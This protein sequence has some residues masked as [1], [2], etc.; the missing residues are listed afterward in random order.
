M[1]YPKS[2]GIILCGM[3]SRLNEQE[4]LFA[5]VQKSTCA[6]VMP[7]VMLGLAEWE[8]ELNVSNE[9]HCI[10]HFAEAKSHTHAHTHAHKCSL[11]FDIRYLMCGL[12]NLVR[13]VIWICKNRI[14]TQIPI[15]LFKHHIDFCTLANNASCASKREHIPHKNGTEWFGKKHSFI[16]MYDNL[17]FT[18]DF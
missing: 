4:A 18:D 12:I 13:D 3:R 10:M 9:M 15:V 7:T 11:I 1:F 2:F 14:N 17:L 8:N 5:R 16:I 6:K